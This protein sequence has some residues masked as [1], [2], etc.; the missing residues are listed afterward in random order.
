MD[1]PAENKLIAVFKYEEQARIF[2]AKNV[3][4]TYVIKE[5]RPAFLKQRR[6]FQGCGFKF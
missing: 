3:S 5:P 1:L 6:G 2:G 4:R